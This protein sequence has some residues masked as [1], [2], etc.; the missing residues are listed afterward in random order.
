ME[1]KSDAKE[2]IKVSIILWE[3]TLTQ[4]SFSRNVVFLAP[5]KRDPSFFFRLPHKCVP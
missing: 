2:K 1:K 3:K 4:F 5:K